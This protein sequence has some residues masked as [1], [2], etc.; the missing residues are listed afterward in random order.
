MREDNKLLEE[1]NQE[2]RTKMRKENKLNEIFE[3]R[4]DQ[5]RISEMSLDKL[6]EIKLLMEVED[7]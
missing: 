5:G 2:L 1:E 7:L 3:K 6:L 4:M